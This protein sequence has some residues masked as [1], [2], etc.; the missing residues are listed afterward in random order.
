M[1][2]TGCPSGSE[3]RVVNRGSTGCAVPSVREVWF[4]V[5][6]VARVACLT[7]GI[8]GTLNAL[9]GQYFCVISALDIS[10]FSGF[11]FKNKCGG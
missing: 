9:E 4:C 10:G 2:Y 7:F 1:V 8:Y 3:L 11:S 6:Y 5:G